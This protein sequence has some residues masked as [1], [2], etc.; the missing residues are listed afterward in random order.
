MIRGFDPT[1][2]LAA[3]ALTCLFLWLLQPIARRFNLL[4]HPHGRKDHAQP[5]PVT[6][7][8]AMLLACLFAYW[9]ATPITPSLQAF[10]MASLLLV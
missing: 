10:C 2:A 1:S 9:S 7:G 6:G 5:T 8:L 3:F 4:D